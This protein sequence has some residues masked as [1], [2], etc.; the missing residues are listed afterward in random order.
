MDATKLWDVRFAGP[1]FIDLESDITGSALGR[2][3]CGRS[4]RKSPGREGCVYR[5]DSGEKRKIT[6][7]AHTTKPI[8]IPRLELCACVLLSQ[9]RAAEDSTFRRKSAL[10]ETEQQIE[11]MEMMHRFCERNLLLSKEMDLDIK[12]QTNLAELAQT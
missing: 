9:L 7:F 5:K 2:T 3:L 11:A 4:T 10:S 6:A 1:R 12:Q 8:A